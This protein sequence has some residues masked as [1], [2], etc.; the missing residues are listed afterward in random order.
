MEAYCAPGSRFDKFKVH[1]G[2]PEQAREDLSGGGSYTHITLLATGRTGV[3]NLFKLSTESF[4]TGFYNKPRID[5]A[6]LEELREG[7]LIGSGCL[8]S[9]LQTRISLGQNEEALAY[10]RMMKEKFGDAFFIEVMDHG[11]DRESNN[12]QPL[13]DIGESLDIRVVATN[14][15]HYI[16]RE[17]HILHDAMLCLQTFAKITD[18][19][20]MRFDGDG[21]HLKSR[22]E[23][24]AL[25][26]PVSSLDNTLWVAEQVGDYGDVFDHEL[27]MPKW[28][29]EKRADPNEILF[30]KFRDGLIERIELDDVD[31]F[32]EYMDRG[33]LELSVIR[34]G[35]FPD[36]FLVM[37]D[38]VGFAKR[39]GIRVM[40]RG[41][42]LGSL[43]LYCLGI[44]DVDP[45]KEE[46]LF[47]RFLNP[48]RVSLPDIDLD[49]Q[50]SRR[51]EVIDY[52]IATYGEAYCTRIS[53]IGTI[54]A[55][56]ALNDSAR[57]L[58]RPFGA[59]AKL[60]RALPRAEFG[61]QPELSEADMS[62]VDDNEVWDLATRLEGLAS[63]SGVHAS[64]FVI[65]PV[66]V[67]DVLPTFVPKRD[68]T[69]QATQWDMHAVEQLGLVKFDFL[70]SKTLDVIDD[71]LKFAGVEL[72]TQ[73]DDP[74]I[75]ELLSSGRTLGVFQ[76]DGSGMR[77][78]LKR[79]APRKF[80]DIVALVSLY[81]PGPMGASA[82]TQ[83][84]D[85][86]NGKEMVHYP[87]P[88]FE[89]S[90][91]DILAP[92]Y[93]VV[94]YQEQVMQILQRVCG[95]SLGQADL[96]RKAMGKKDRELL[97]GEYDRYSQ[98]AEA[99]GYGVEATARLWE[100]LVPF[101]DY[102]FNKSHAHGYALAAYSTAWLKLYHPE[103]FMSAL[104]THE[105]DI[106]SF[107]EYLGEVRR[108][109]ITILPPSINGG[110]TWTPAE[111][112]IHYGLASIKGV[113]EKA[114][115]SLQRKAPYSGWADFLRRAPKTSLNIGIVKALIGAGA[116][117]GF[118]S[119]EGLLQ[120]V[121]VHLEEASAERAEL[122]VGETGFTA[123]RFDIPDVAADY[124]ERRRTEEE[125]LGIGLSAAAGVV[126]VE[127]ADRLGWAYLR[128]AIESNP[129]Q[130]TIKITCGSW[131]MKIPNQ[132]D[133][134]GLR[135]ALVPVGFVVE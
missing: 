43:V 13:V 129:G 72:P 52:A 56:K 110:A 114:I 87:H 9:E 49:I 118:G 102:A 71:A 98:G 6:L 69:A 61:R 48:E 112:G 70:G 80:G 47:E 22:R 57:V 51:E 124:A 117:D 111:G 85:R 45:I 103:A 127:Q 133:L 91:R 27:R 29:E 95:Y 73:F 17:D 23:M 12:I 90:L 93:G 104:L 78:L 66:P 86:L 55:K 96:V 3:R 119:R 46:L 5:L 30:Q 1:W 26:L 31:V 58:G 121:D 41:S 8:S 130:S 44:S 53:T 28:A 34:Q 67:A 64:A 16:T 77:G 106:D 2:T 54:K 42:A 75:Y 116:L 37:D 63:A 101:A 134:D 135:R 62:F 38:L 20:R 108:M 99:N 25:A 109:G 89:S 81:R 132:V 122:D 39:S 33:R 65:S 76:L 4:A 128:K 97:A 84:A 92:T 94:V 59:G 15:C 50:K 107:P 82:H 125:T 120:L 21:Y 105:G 18:E 123:R 40:P 10:A 113:G 115:A 14:D 7:L 35:E 60:A 36:Y 88:E 32:Q 11:F 79:M 100:I 131:T 83:Y 126:T 68:S 74:A 24:E 19:K